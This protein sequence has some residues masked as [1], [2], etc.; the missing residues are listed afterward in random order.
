[1]LILIPYSQFQLLRNFSAYLIKSYSNTIETICLRFLL[2][3]RYYT[4]YYFTNE[5]KCPE[6]KPLKQSKQFID[7]PSCLNIEISPLHFAPKK[8]NQN[9]FR[10]KKGISFWLKEKV[11]INF[12]IL[13]VSKSIHLSPSV[14]NGCP[15]DKK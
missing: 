5:T 1:M 3:R 12:R 8:T 2:F 10:G 11:K 14:D 15:T 4:T 6:G 13:K 7:G 9:K